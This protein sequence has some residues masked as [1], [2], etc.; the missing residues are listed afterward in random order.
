MLTPVVAH[1]FGKQLAVVGFQGLAEQAA[2]VEGVLAQHA[3]A[4]AV[5][6]RHRRL[7]HPL[8]G[9]LQAPGAL[10]PF[11]GGEVGLQGRQQGITLG[12]TTKHRGGFHQARTDAITQLAG[13]GIGEGHHQ[14]LRRQQRL[15]ERRLAA[16]TEDQAQVQRRD[17]VGLAGT[18]AGLDQ[19]AAVQRET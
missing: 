3:L 16:M 14:N 2:A 10:R 17:G 4:P 5:N 1:H 15:A 19:T 18:G 13:G 6:G 7:V 12:I 8:R 9:Q 11:G